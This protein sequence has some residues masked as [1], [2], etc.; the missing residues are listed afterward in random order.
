MSVR[1]LSLSALALVFILG[2]EAEGQD[3]RNG[4]IVSK[5]SGSV[6]VKNCVKVLV[7]RD[8]LGYSVTYS[9]K[10]PGMKSVHVSGLGE[11]PG[12][13]DFRYLTVEKQLEFRDVVSGRVL[14]QVPL[15][16]T[17]VP[18]GDA[19]LSDV[20]GD[21]EFQNAFRS[22]IWESPESLQQRANYVLGKH[23][24]YSP[25]EDHDVMF[26][27]TTFAPLPLMEVRNGIL[28]RIALRLSF[29]YDPKSG[30]YAFHVQTLIKEGRALSDDYRST[31]DPAI[32]RS[33]DAFVDSIVKEMQGGAGG[34]P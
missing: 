5:A 28:A 24:H 31:N 7:G 23:F 27:A 1:R 30:K 15:V 3:N 11:V 26:L 4:N 29:P 18:A 33:A 14:L 13:G 20:P 8:K 10:F 25:R 17:I 32:V 22:F 34:H 9:Y 2:Y 16:E 12:D 19:P 21:N 6:E